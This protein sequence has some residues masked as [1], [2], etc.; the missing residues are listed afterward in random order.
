VKILYVCFIFLVLTGCKTPDAKQPPQIISEQNNKSSL[1]GTK[2]LVISENEDDFPPNYKIEFLEGGV[3]FDRYPNDGH[4][5]EQ[6]ENIVI[7][8]WNQGSAK[9]V[10]L[11]I[12]ENN[13]KCILIN[14]ES[15]YCGNYEMRRE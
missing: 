13:I 4:Y 3:L 6:K 14:E 9:S 7:I 8:Y 2:W 10:G 12:S 11:I 5:W 1:V 15:G